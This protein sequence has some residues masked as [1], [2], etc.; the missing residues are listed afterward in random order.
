MEE[1][2]VFNSEHEAIEDGTLWGCD[3]IRLTL[4]HI[5]LLLSGK[6]LKTDNGEYVQIIILEESP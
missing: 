5:G 3:T 2:R 6:A 4:D 1:F